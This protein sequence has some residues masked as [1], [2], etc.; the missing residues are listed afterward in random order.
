MIS[1]FATFSRATIAVTM[2]MSGVAFAQT[3]P[4]NNRANTGNA[5]ATGTTC[6]SFI[7]AD[8]GEGAGSRGAVCSGFGGLSTG[9]IVVGALL[10]GLA[11]AA[12]A[13]GNGSN[14]SGVTGTT[15][16]TR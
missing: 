8:G 14:G 2:L 16:S 9:A 3:A 5:A 1:K 11:I 7:P 13:S 4:S 12:A 10:G 6:N 15:A